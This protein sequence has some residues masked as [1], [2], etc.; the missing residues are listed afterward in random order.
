[1]D[2]TA[3]IVMVELTCVPKLCTDLRHTVLVGDASPIRV[4]VMETGPSGRTRP[5]TVIR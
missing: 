2:S 5:G 4:L 3:P 1:M